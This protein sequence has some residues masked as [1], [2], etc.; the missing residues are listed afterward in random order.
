MFSF[1][2]WNGLS[3]EVTMIFL[4]VSWI[5]LSLATCCALIL[6]YFRILVLPSLPILMPLWCLFTNLVGENF[7]YINCSTGIFSCSFPLIPVRL[8]C[9][10]MAG[11]Y[12]HLYSQARVR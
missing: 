3:Q 2:W 9:L 10:A 5:L 7:C 11:A 1:S 8:N 12:S 4:V 6:L